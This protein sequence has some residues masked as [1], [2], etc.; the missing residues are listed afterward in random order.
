VPD[1]PRK[2]PLWLRLIR[3]IGLVLLIL[4]AAIVGVRA[5]DAFTGPPLPPWLT[6]APEE[7][8]AAA[9]DAMDWPTWQAAEDRLMGEVAADLERKLLPEERIAQNRFWKESPLN[10]GQ[11]ARDWNRSFTLAP[12][13]PAKGAVVLLHGLTDSP[14]SL[15]HIAFFYQARGF[16][17]V[18]PRMPGHGTVPGGLTNVSLDQWQAAARL[19]MREAKAR[20]GGGPVHVVGYSNG[21]S[22]ALRHAL[23]A[24]EKPDLVRPDRVLLISPMIGVSPAARLAGI[25]GWPALLPAFANAAWLDRTLEFNPFKYNSFPVHAAKLSERQTDALARELEA[26]RR[27]GALDK[28]PPIMAFQSVVDATVIAGAV[29]ERLLDRLP[30]G[31]HEL[32]LFDVNHQS[33]AAPL[34][35]QSARAVA[36]RFTPGVARSYRTVLITNNGTADGKVVA[37]TWEAGTTDATDVPVAIPYPSHLFSLSHVALP[38]PPED[39]LYGFQPDPAD[40]Q[41]AQLGRLLVQGERNTIS[42]SQDILTRAS[43]NPFFP[44]ILDRLAL[45]PE[46]GA[47]VAGETPSPALEPAP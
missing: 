7:P 12:E 39:G 11:L 22:I 30:A 20:S 10:P 47:K 3:R 18:A 19:A 21:A 1:S 34:L 36:S 23:A 5:W 32:I 31:G 40:D 33:L 8:S 43:S 41:G 24:L 6:M 17:V 2:R 14:Y 27:A 45:E 38:F 37:R 28:M 16:H 13:G 46:E 42:V 25:A 44:L 35:T 26:A 9:I 29:Q 15:R 4:V